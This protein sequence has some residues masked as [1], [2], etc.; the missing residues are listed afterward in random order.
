MMGHGLL[1]KEVK[2]YYQGPIMVWRGFFPPHPPAADLTLEQSIQACAN[3][4][5]KVKA[6]NQESVS[7]QESSAAIEQL[8]KG[9]ASYINRLKKQYKQ[10]KSKPLNRW[11]DAICQDIDRLQALFNH[12][13]RYNLFIAAD[14]IMPLIDFF[15]SILTHLNKTNDS[16]YADRIRFYAIMCYC[17][18]GVA[19]VNLE[20]IIEARIYL[21]TILEELE[22]L[23]E[24]A[25]KSNGYFGARSLA[26]NYLVQVEIK[27]KNLL[28]ASRNLE[29]ALIADPNAPE[30]IS[31]CTVLSTAYAEKN[32]FKNAYYWLNKALDCYGQ[33]RVEPG[34]NYSELNQFKENIS[35]HRKTLAVYL[36]KHLDQLNHFLMQKKQVFVL[37]R[38][39]NSLNL[40]TDAIEL[41][42]H[43]I[44]TCPTLTV[45]LKDKALILKPLI[46][47]SFKQI[48][49]MVNY[50]EQANMIELQNQLAQLNLKQHSPVN[51]IKEQEKLIEGTPAPIAFS[52]PA[53]KTVESKPED[54]QKPL[55]I[56][57]HKLTT[58]KEKLT[59]PSKSIS[60]AEQLGFSEN[61][62]GDSLF[63]QCRTRGT[64][65]PFYV[66][67]AKNLGTQ[68]NGPPHEVINDFVKNRFPN[69]KIVPFF[70]EEGFKWWHPKKQAGE[71]SPPLL[72]CKNKSEWR[73]FPTDYQINKHGEFAFLYGEFQHTKN[74][75]WEKNIRKHGMRVKKPKS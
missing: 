66:V 18:L 71:K 70:A 63:Y 7:C 44:P 54:E 1:H 59:T 12:L 13:F 39:E 75:L 56:L 43:L 60:A 31:N 25:K 46:H 72:Y 73:L 28:W 27:A 36:Q 37:N 55:A 69:A 62:F 2:E 40:T 16:S 29:S 19:H 17:N 6:F 21:D 48:K 11:L 30:C 64:I 45:E 47:C 74:G 35:T 61:I 68:K 24:H 22:K 3:S 23:S 57:H 33:I 8:Q 42:A 38:A 58:V 5:D 34:I 26:Y 10:F 14:E 9:I 32:D 65:R 51:Q 20:N 41:P 67:P 15:S 4:I 50:I 52:E 53:E 49:A